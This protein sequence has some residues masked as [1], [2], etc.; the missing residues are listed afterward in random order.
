MLMQDSD[1]VMLIST[2][3]AQKIL[4]FAFM[5]NTGNGQNP[6]VNRLS[7]QQPSLLLLGR[8]WPVSCLTS[9]AKMMFSLAMI[10][11]VLKTFA[12]PSCRTEGAKNHQ[13]ISF[14]RLC[15]FAR[16]FIYLFKAQAYQFVL[17]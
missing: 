6:A 3:S 13:S 15:C 1:T 4:I 2:G 8:K 17:L 9:S 5:K 11:D 16:F 14:G 10:K 7:L 12:G